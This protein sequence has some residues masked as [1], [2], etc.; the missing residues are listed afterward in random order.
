MIIG[1]SENISANEANE[2]N[3]DNKLNEENE[4][5][6]E[7]KDNELNEENEENEVNED[8]EVNE[9]NEV[10]ED[11]EVNEEKE[12]NEANKIK[13]VNGITPS[14]SIVYVDGKQ[15]IY[16]VYPILKNNSTLVPLRETFEA[17]GAVVTWNKREQKV[18]AK[19]GNK[20]VI[21]YINSPVGYVDGQSISLT[22]SP[23]LYKDMTMIPLRFVG[24]AFGGE[25][26]YDVTTKMINI[27]MPKFIVNF[28]PTEF[29]TLSNLIPVEG[30]K[31][32]GK[33]RLMVSDNPEIL[34]ADT[35]KNINETLWNDIVVENRYIKDHRVFAWHIN[36][37]AQNITLGITIENRSETNTLE[38]RDVK[39]LHKISQNTWYEHDIG[40]P[41]AESLLTDRLQN[42]QLASNKI[43][44]GET[45]LIASYQMN[46]NDALGLL[47]DF[48][49]VKNSGTGSM[50]YVIRTVVSGV[51][52]EDLTNIKS[53]PAPLDVNRAHPRGVWASS[54]LTVNLPQF[55]IAEVNEVTYTISNGQTDDVFTADNSLILPENSIGNKGHFGVVYKVEIPYVNT[56]D[57]P[58]TIQVRIG[59]R[60]GTYSGAIKTKYGVYNIPTI[61]AARDVA[62]VLDEKVEVQ[63]AGTV[64]LSI[65]HAG[66]ASLPIAINVRTIE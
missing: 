37:L 39:G 31:M 64:E 25:V 63:S 59:S 48:T 26:D 6:E 12:V 9:E 1:Y 10:N 49:V 17:M 50:D 27:T 35:I 40:L 18:T 23:I 3:K 16:S 60:G 8:N 7:N 33:R 30:A 22:T 56:T 54:D 24:E 29:A 28:L 51:E 52:G 11:N 65:V 34:N 47:N 21:L 44:P 45:I 57:E 43:L 14:S 4:V 19:N 38:I 46:V 58:K 55:K 13:D 41:I 20:E 61:E 53:T 62:I 42:I 5:N 36:E 66:G 15:V 2:V 32:T